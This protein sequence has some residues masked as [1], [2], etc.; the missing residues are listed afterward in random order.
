MLRNK[1]FILKIM[2]KKN[3]CMLEDRHFNLT[4]NERG[5]LM[6]ARQKSDSYE[7]GPGGT[8]AMAAS[9]LNGDM[10]MNSAEMESA[11]ENDFVEEPVPAEHRVIWPSLAFVA[12]GMAMFVGLYYT[13]VQLGTSMGNLSNALFAILGGGIFLGFF[14]ALNGLIGYKTGCNTALA[15]IYAYGSV[16]ALIPSFYVADLGWFLIM[17]AQFS[18][19]LSG[20]VPSI[21]SRVFCIIFSIL[22]ITNGFI[23]F[24]QMAKLNS[25]AMPILLLTGL[26]GVLR[27]HLITPGGLAG[28]FDKTFPD[29]ISMG[30]AMTAVVGTWVAGASRALDY[31]RFAKRTK[32]VLIAAT[33]GFTFGFLLCISVGAIWGAGS[34]TTNIS[35]TLALLG[36]GMIFFGALM[37]FL[38]TWTTNEHSAYVTSAALPVFVKIVSGKNVRRRTIIAFN[39]I[40]AIAF[41][42]IGLEKYFLP[43][44]QI[45][46]ILIPVIGAILLTD[47]FI[48]SRTSFHWTGHKNFYQILVTDEDVTHHKF[49]CAVIPTLVIGALIGWKLQVGI[50]AINSLFGT[51][52]CYII[53]SFVFSMLQINKA[54]IS[55][56]ISLEQRRTCGQAA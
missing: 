53:F 51:M 2:S 32:D 56:N 10:E 50:P 7:A 47:F 14:M 41:S 18:L 46:G 42:G 9:S 43:F 21:D 5:I 20:L 45:M 54:E 37:F 38:Q 4:F 35:D 22:F 28:V 13:G 15:S 8:A 12:F 17:I 3:A 23:G 29:E 25:M 11:L 27:V 26:Y 48:V 36:G 44:L 40:L 19:I 30:V 6:D 16:G 24:K 31:Y 39:A 49:N 55:K 1:R 34:G 33:L 52:L